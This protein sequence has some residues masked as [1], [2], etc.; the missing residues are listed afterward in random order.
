MSDQTRPELTCSTAISSICREPAVPAAFIL[1][2]PSARPYY[3]MRHH[4]PQGD[5]SLQLDGA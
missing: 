5:F 4:P 3:T 1:P 2:F